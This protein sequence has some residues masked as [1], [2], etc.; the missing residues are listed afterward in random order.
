MFINGI[1][2]AHE[3]HFYNADPADSVD[4]YHFSLIFLLFNL[5]V[6]N[7]HGS[8]P[9]NE[10]KN[11]KAISNKSNSPTNNPNYE[12]VKYISEPSPYGFYG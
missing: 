7:M 6:Y 3:F 11:M 10:S 4:P 5:N 9:I 2:E 12:R 8:Q 1:W